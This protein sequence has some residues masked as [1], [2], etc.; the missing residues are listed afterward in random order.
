M[1]RLAT[2]L[3]TAI[4]RLMTLVMGV[5][6]AAAVCVVLLTLTDIILR[7]VDR[8][9]SLLNGSKFG[10]A[11]V[12]LVDIS[13]LLIMLTAAL[14]ISVAFY[15]GSHVSV[16]LLTARFSARGIRFANACAGL[17]N[18]IFTVG[19]LW[20]GFKTM[21]LDL[22]VGTSS[23]TI[24]ISYRAFWLSLLIGL[25]LSC[26]GICSHLL[27]GLVDHTEGSDLEPKGVDYV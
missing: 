4:D 2:M 17:L 27:A 12:G 10:W 11:I 13:Q 24:G 22:E 21:Q 8:L 23:A 26:L 16:D 25:A 19:C 6:F 7:N 3:S 14:A 1:F 5:S 20:A 15:R 18:L 9:C